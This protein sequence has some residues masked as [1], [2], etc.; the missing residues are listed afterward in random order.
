MLNPKN[1]SLL[2]LLIISCKNVEEKLDYESELILKEQF[3]INLDDKTD[4]NFYYYEVV[5]W[6][7]KECLAVINQVNNS[8][9]FYDLDIGEKV[10]TIPIPMD[11]PFGLGYVQ[12][13]TYVNSDSVFLYKRGTFR[14][15]ILIDSSGEVQNSYFPGIKEQSAK[16]LVN[17][18]SIPKNPTYFKNN[19]LHFISYPL[20]DNQN[21]DNFHKNVLHAGRFGLDSL[22]I[23]FEKASGFPPI[24]WNKTWNS[25]SCSVSRVLGENDNWVY[26]WDLL[27][28]LFVFDFEHQ[29][30]ESYYV[31]SKLRPSKLDFAEFSF[32]NDAMG[33][34]LYYSI[35]YDKYRDCYYRI[36]FVKPKVK[37]EEIPG[38]HRFDFFPFVIMVLDKNFNVISEK[39][40]PSKMY[41]PTQ[42]FVGEKGFYLP[43]SNGLNPDLKE[44]KILY[45]LYQIR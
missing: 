6:Q 41:K 7:N 4:Y 30:R 19:K 35:K 17:H 29:S 25:P 2:F 20:E 40:F 13:F 44:N 3:V 27:D 5:N 36:Y 43:L 24:F 9:D 1:F 42:S 34:N 33:S 10:K 11:G 38:I 8:L 31:K 39:Y 37:V 28:S 16:D 15:S 22:S 23:S 26:S 12:G 14:G 18:V 45:E 21:P 32:P